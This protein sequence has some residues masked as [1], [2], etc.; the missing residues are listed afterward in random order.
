MDEFTRENFVGPATQAI[1]DY[2]RNPRAVHK[3]IKMYE[4]N[5]DGIIILDYFLDIVL[6]HK[7][8]L[9]AN[10]EV[11]KCLVLSENRFGCEVDKGVYRI[12][13]KKMRMNGRVGID[14]L[15][16][17]H[18]TI[19]AAQLESKIH[20]EEIELK[21]MEDPDEIDEQLQSI[22]D[23]KKLLKMSENIKNVEFVGGSMVGYFA[24]LKLTKRYPTNR[25]YMRLFKPVEKSFREEFDDED[26]IKMHVDFIRT[27][28]KNKKLKINN[29]IKDIVTKLHVPSQAQAAVERRAA[30]MVSSARNLPDELTD[31]IKSNMHLGEGTKTKK[32][33]KRPRRTRSKTNGKTKRSRKKN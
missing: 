23:N 4:N 27:G 18:A 12:D 28:V 32:R 5:L 24:F 29:D 30:R 7:L 10:D 17:D 16:E 31:V 11:L 26:I 1:K 6:L 33:Q 22:H 13:I 19:F 20:D 8:L 15:L 3:Q 25:D 9:Y 2:N 14:Y 21:E